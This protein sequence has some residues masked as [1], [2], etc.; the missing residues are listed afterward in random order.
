MCDPTSQSASV[1]V[2]SCQSNEGRD[3]RDARQTWAF[4]LLSS[5]STSAIAIR[6]C[7]PRT[8]MT[9]TPRQIAWNGCAALQVFNFQTRPVVTGLGCD[10]NHEREQGSV[11][12]QQT[13]TPS[14]ELSGLAKTLTKEFIE[15][16]QL[17]LRNHGSRRPWSELHITWLDVCFVDTV[18]GRINVAVVV[19]MIV[20]REPHLDGSA[21]H[22]DTN[23]HRRGGR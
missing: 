7:A 15:G 19:T 14:T 8:E 20:C 16:R 3:Q 22:D 6:G 13:N 9:I 10:H 4:T 18:G 21:H 17:A 2:S 1:S 12:D 5:S 11:G 23:H